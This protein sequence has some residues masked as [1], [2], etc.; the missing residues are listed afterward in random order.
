MGTKATVGILNPFEGFKH[1]SLRREAPPEDLAPFVERFWS[2]RWDLDG[3]PP[4]AQEILPYPCVN[5]STGSGGFEVH[6]P[7]TKRF[8]ARLSGRG[9]VFGT[10][11]TPAGFLV[12]TRTPLRDLVDR[13]VSIEAAAGRGPC[14]P[15]THD[16]DAVRPQ[17]ETF[18]RSFHPKPTEA[19][20]LADRLVRLAQE[21]RSITRAEDLA[22]T[23]GISVRS[24]HRLFEHHVGV[25]PKWVIRRSRVQEAAE[26]VARGEPV[27][28]AGAAQELGYHDQ[29]HLIRDFREQVGATPA[30]YARQCGASVVG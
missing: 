15:T 19:M 24:L 6:G 2:V 4:F 22:R 3:R 7:A 26:R 21:D 11:F 8:V 10:K 18:L 5:L 9:E 14:A 29:A 17:V 13:I 27:D 16:F 28:W 30:A 25:G 1:F 23:A 12:F 20:A